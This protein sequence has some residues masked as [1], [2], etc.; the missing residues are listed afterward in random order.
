MR[1]LSQIQLLLG[2]RLVVGSWFQVRKLV[3]RGGGVDLD[4][5][6]FVG[7]GRFQAVGDFGP[8][9]VGNLMVGNLEVFDHEIL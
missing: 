1:Q 5:G 4:L 6:G 9:L 2:V 8:R 7:M 3:G